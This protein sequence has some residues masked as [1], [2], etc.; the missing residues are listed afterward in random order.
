LQYTLGITEGALI[1]LRF[2]IDCPD[3]PRLVAAIAQ[4]VY[5]HGGNTFPE[6]T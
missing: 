2:L 1:I 6:G 3:R 5:A 4:F